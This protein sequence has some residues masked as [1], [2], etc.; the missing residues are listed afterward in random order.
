MHSYV[1][2]N[3]QVFARGIFIQQSCLAMTVYVRKL[4]FVELTTLSL[5]VLPSV[6]KVE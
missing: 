6:R 4:R 1:S 5:F 3:R 2:A